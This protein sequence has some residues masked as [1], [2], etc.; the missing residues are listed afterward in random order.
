MDNSRR[1]GNDRRKQTGIN[2]R[3]IVGNGSRTIIR[4]QEDQGRIFLVDQYSPILFVT[5][6]G[7]LFLCVIDAL[8]TLFLLNHGAYETNPIISYLLNIS[9]YAFFV[10]K[11]VLTFVATI[12]LFMFRGVVVQKF[13][14]STHSFLYF[15]A[16]MYVA[17]VT[18]ELYLV[19]NVIWSF[20][21]QGP[22]ELHA[23]ISSL[24]C[25]IH[26]Y[27]GIP[28]SCGSPGCRYFIRYCLPQLDWTV[29]F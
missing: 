29:R 20:I 4:R 11:F 6:V 7:I 19:Y 15:L 2:V 9:P 17:V 22:F 8:L 5:I 27:L 14:I 26:K 1:S 18:W 13:N 25:L 21:P 12:C 10:P 28:I 16:W 24:I 3:M 23:H